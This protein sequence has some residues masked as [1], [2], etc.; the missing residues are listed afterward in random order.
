MQSPEREHQTRKRQYTIVT[1]GISI[2]RN[3]QIL[4]GGML[5]GGG[6]H[7]AWVAETD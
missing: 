3:R 4:D 7:D 6:Y 1:Q 2:A 5:S